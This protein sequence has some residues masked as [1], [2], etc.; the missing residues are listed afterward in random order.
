MHVVL[1]GTAVENQKTG[2][3][4]YAK[5]LLEQL[6]R[7]DAEL[8]Y[9]LL[10]R[11]HIV[12]DHPVVR[13]SGENRNLAIR[14]VDI[15]P[16]GPKREL[17]FRGMERHYDVFHS[18]S[19]NLPLAISERAVVTIHDLKYVLYPHYLGRL[20]S[21]KSWYLNT[22][23]RHAARTAAR[24]ITVSEATRRDFI[25]RYQPRIG[26]TSLGPKTTTIHEA[27]GDVAPESGDVA[28]QYRLYDPYFLYVGELRPHK[29]VEGL[30]EAYRRFRA[31]RI[32]SEE[33]RRRSA[34]PRLLIA[35]KPHKSFEIP[36]GV[37]DG[38]EF[39]GYVSD[40]EL[41]TLYRR[42]RAFCL[43]SHYEGFGLPVLEAMSYG[44]PVITSN[45]SSLPEVAGD[46]ALRVSP[47]DPA[48]T[49]S[50]MEAIEADERLREQL[51]ERGR[52]RAAA[53]SWEEAAMK[54]LA[55]YRE[56][57]ETGSSQA[58]RT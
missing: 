11:Q 54:T 45:V 6:L 42:A 25:D 28:R 22:V 57:A 16:I 43:V 49:A 50:A 7:L 53:F 18:L 24:V 17:R 9:T 15:P 19:S 29:N 31:G 23:F 3:S 48:S 51:S 27:G 36:E 2:V 52:K 26:D 58:S 10:L 12:P 44:T 1:D 37:P 46:A 34:V 39:I 35:G 47:D 13:L 40:N 4:Q 20:S 56:V 30:I 8:H 5:K 21:L 41:P 33:P 55:V 14:W 32:E 38:V